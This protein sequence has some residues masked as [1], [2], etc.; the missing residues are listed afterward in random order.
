MSVGELDLHRKR[1]EYYADIDQHYLKPL[2]AALKKVFTPEPTT[3]AQAHIWRWHDVR[4][5]L[6]RAGEVVTAE[7]AERR[8]LYLQNP[9][10][11]DAPPAIT[12]T[13][14]AGVQLILPGEVAPSHRH[15]A[16]ALRFIM[17]GDGAYTSVDGEQTF[18]SPGDFVLTPNWTW[19]DHGNTSD[20]PMIWLDGLDLP[21]V[22]YLNQIFAEEYDD[23]RYPLTRP[24]DQSIWKYGSGL[25]PRWV[26]HQ[27]PHSPV[28]NYKWDRTYKTLKA[29]AADDRGSP[30]DD[31]IFEYTNPLTGGPALPTMSAFIQLLRPGSVTRA[32]QHTSSTVYL[33]VDGTGATEI[34]GKEF[35]WG[36]YDIFVV[37]TWARHRHL[38]ASSSAEAILFSFSDEAI[39][40]PLGLYRERGE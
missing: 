21:A 14:Y 16:A 25:R 40:K 6:M 22:M 19:H 37:P 24:A 20:Q 29:L 36:K 38:N 39:L 13:L 3:N 35:K 33:V 31:T 4:P 32:H 18:M 1:Q 11:G 27:A 5:R 30:Y 12:Q 2:W 17:E 9:G 23:A 10:L 28:V 7:E 34:D 8:V 15:S 26:Q